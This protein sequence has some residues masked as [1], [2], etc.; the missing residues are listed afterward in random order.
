MRNLARLFG[1]GDASPNVPEVV[2]EAVPELVPSVAGEQRDTANDASDTAIEVSASELQSVQRVSPEIIVPNPFQPRKT[3]HDESLQELSASI[4][5]FGVIQPLLVR[6]QG[7]RFELIAGERRLRA[8]KLAGL[9]EVPVIVRELDDKE[10]AELA[11][12]ENLQREDLH[13]LEEAE[14]YQHLIA[15]FN[16]TQ[17]ELARRVGKNQS[18]IANK[19]RLLKLAPEVRQAVVGQSLTERHARAL[20][21]L[22][23]TRVQMEVLDGVRE[24]G[25]NV[26]ATEDLIE[27]YT[28]NI[29]REKNNK[30][31]TPKQTLVKI[32]KDV[33]IF[34]NTINS[35]IS[36]MKKSGMDIKVK[37]DIEGDYVTINIQVKNS[38]K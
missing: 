1:I 29:S 30:E 4:R 22:E 12:I 24:N 37:Q 20:L 27:T 19:L 25:L 28:D 8:S 6:R 10:M 34:I 13:F 14:G 33:R 26:R 2:A 17:E 18:T 23:D 16:F 32:I 36:Q 5:E 9:D 15:S 3:F 21:K 31:V 35:V 7:E 38:R 11:M